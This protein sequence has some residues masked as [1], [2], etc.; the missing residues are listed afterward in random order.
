M[1]KGLT[2]N[3]GNPWLLMWESQTMNIPAFPTMHFVTLLLE[4]EAIDLHIVYKL[5]NVVSVFM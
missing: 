2:E 4:T 5:K 3:N 1:V